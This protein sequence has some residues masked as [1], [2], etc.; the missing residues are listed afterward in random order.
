MYLH[1]NVYKEK[2]ITKTLEA[3]ELLCEIESIAIC[4]GM[5]SVEEFN[6]LDTKKSGCYRVG[7]RLF[8]SKCT[9]AAASKGAS[10]KV[11]YCNAKTTLHAG[12]RGRSCT[13][14]KYY[15]KVSQ[16]RMWK[17]RNKTKARFPTTT[18]A[19]KLRKALRN[20]KSQKRSINTLLEKMEQADINSTRKIHIHT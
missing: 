12:T 7:N 14:C 17:A 5:G 15:R 2:T 9:G 4:E 19:K 20:A 8:A 6:L 10:F 16:T 1:G 11:C 18:A 3:E 13:A